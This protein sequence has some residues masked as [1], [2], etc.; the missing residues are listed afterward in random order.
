MQPAL[1]CF[2]F[3]MHF[4]FWSCTRIGYNHVFGTCGT[5][6]VQVRFAPTQFLRVLDKSCRGSFFFNRWE[7][8]FLIPFS[9]V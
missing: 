6:R 1:A 9:I 2:F 4:R 3:E 8:V 5:F 7:G